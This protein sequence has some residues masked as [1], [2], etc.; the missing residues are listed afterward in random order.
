[1]KIKFLKKLKYAFL[2]TAVMFSTDA[3]SQLTT[4]GVITTITPG[5]GSIRV[6]GNFTG[7]PGGCT[8]GSLYVLL[9]SNER[10][11]ELYAG[12]LTAKATQEPVRL[13]LGPCVT[14]GSQNIGEI[15]SIIIQ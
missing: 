14:D 12:L 9:Y 7:N 5:S 6:E 2:A 3:F 4:S 15:K 13:F 1:M 8:N 11:K 10:Y